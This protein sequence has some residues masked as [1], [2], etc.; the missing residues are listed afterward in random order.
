MGDYS[1]A[2]AMN[3]YQGLAGEIELLQRGS[4]LTVEVVL[5][6]EGAKAV[7]PDF[8]YCQ[9]SKTRT[10]FVLFTANN[11]DGAWKNAHFDLLYASLPSGDR[12]FLFDI[13]AETDAAREKFE[14]LCKSMTEWADPTRIY[15]WS[16]VT[17]ANYCRLLK[18]QPSLAGS[19]MTCALDSLFMVYKS[20]TVF[21]PTFFASGDEFPV[22]IEG[23]LNAADED[24][25]KCRIVR[26]LRQKGAWGDTFADLTKIDECMGRGN[27]TRSIVIDV[28]YEC[29]Q[30][31][32]TATNPEHVVHTYIC[33][34][35]RV[36]PLGDV[37]LERLSTGGKSKKGT[38]MHCMC[39]EPRYTRKPNVGSAKMPRFLA[40][41]LTRAIDGTADPEFQDAI[42][43]DTCVYTLHAVVSWNLSHFRVQVRF[44]KIWTCYDGRQRLN[45][46][47]QSEAFNYD[48]SYG[49]GYSPSQ[50]FYV[51]RDDGYKHIRL[52]EPSR[53]SA[54][55]GVYIDVEED[56]EGELS[57][58]NEDGE[59]VPT[60]VDA[61]VC[62]D[63]GDEYNFPNDDSFLDDP[64]GY[65][66][67]QAD[68]FVFSG[69]T[70]YVRPV[71]D[72]RN[73]VCAT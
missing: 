14:G 56:G 62:R 48:F 11:E 65:G 63:N 57:Q 20:M 68:P 46:T 4:A 41:T 73:L 13:G 30:C 53:R 44:G 22:L 35:D 10:A 58:T 60:S 2:A 29:D 67:H 32:T 16:D 51:S 3:G 25:A 36:R 33:V 71:Y 34:A 72:V 37:L 15:T 27:P 55:E 23:L 21:H 18:L 40:F 8:V 43:V 61:A 59:D 38:S 66:N 50:L 7:K 49:R 69:K 28:D 19:F 64:F 24:L 31:C 47:S 26:E 42:L 52:Q 70:L 39:R 54:G 45:R 12:K 1:K 5:A 9:K 17:A 6:A